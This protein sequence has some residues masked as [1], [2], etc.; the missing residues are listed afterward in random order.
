MCI[1]CLAPCKKQA[2]LQLN[3][4]CNYIVHYKCFNK[5]WLKTPKCIICRKNCQKPI[6]QYG[7]H[8]K[9]ITPVRRRRR[10]RRYTFNHFTDYDYD[11][12]VEHEIPLN[13]YII[14]PTNNNRNIFTD[15][16]LNRQ[17]AT[18]NVMKILQFLWI[19]FLFLILWGTVSI[20]PSLIRAL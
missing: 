15:Y 12:Q 18:E 20:L 8:N 1:I 10:R 17:N 3:C 6:S 9:V 14:H 11:L 19:C 4:E 2:I 5:W 16:Y 7:K 13:R